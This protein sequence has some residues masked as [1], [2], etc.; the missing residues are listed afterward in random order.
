PDWD[1]PFLLH[2][3]ASEEGTGA[4]L[5]QVQDDDQEHVIA[6]ASHRWSKTN[7]RRASTETECMAI[8][9]AAEH[10]RSYIWGRK[11]TL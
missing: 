11:L 4:T 5:T 7:S 3:D 1:K 10:F 8:L 6:Y 9:W 2:A